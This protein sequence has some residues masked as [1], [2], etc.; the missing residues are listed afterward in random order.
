MIMTAKQTK[1][2]GSL[3]AKQGPLVTD[4]EWLL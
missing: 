1:A 4:E 2:H 3:E